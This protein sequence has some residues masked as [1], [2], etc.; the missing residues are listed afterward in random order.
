MSWIDTAQIN[1]LTRLL[2]AACARQNAITT[3]IANLDTPGYRTK[4]V[5]FRTL[6][7]QADQPGLL[8][9]SAQP[10]TVEVKGLMERPDGNNVSME[11]ESLLLAQTQLQFHT[12]VQLIRSEFRRLQTAINE[13]R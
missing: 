12:G 6:L 3:N 11:R 2:D 8:Q 7:Q 1:A 5:Q 13:G 9:T 10:A 4:D